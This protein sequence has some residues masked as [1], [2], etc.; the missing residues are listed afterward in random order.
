MQTF[1]VHVISCFIF[2]FCCLLSKIPGS[3]PSNIPFINI[4]FGASCMCAFYGMCFYF[5][6]GLNPA[7][8]LPTMWLLEKNRVEDQ[9]RYSTYWLIYLVAPLIGGAL[10]G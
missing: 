4:T 7:I 9:I 3:E 6:G 1:V 2:I 5:G 10:A 8:S